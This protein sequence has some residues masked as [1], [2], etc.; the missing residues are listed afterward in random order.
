MAGL[1]R[2]NHWVRGVRWSCFSIFQ[3]LMID[4]GLKNPSEQ[5]L[6]CEMGWKLVQFSLALTVNY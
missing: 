2:M 5:Q 6:E 1:A 4:P 3:N